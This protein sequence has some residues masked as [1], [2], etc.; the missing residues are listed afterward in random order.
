MKRDANNVIMLDMQRN[1]EGRKKKQCI[2]CDIQV[3]TY[4]FLH[5]IMHSTNLVIDGVG[6]CDDITRSGG[7]VLS[8][9]NN[10]YCDC[11]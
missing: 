9:N 3:T 10:R 1:L 4:H 6:I 5:N 2:P 7:C 11:C 8:I